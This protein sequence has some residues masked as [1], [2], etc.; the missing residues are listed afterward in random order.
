MIIRE[1]QTIYIEENGDGT[2]RYRHEHA[3]RWFPYYDGRPHTALANREWFPR[4]PRQQVIV[5][6][7]STNGQWGNPVFAD[8]DSWKTDNK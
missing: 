4:R 6:V 1:K 7:T 3:T 5:P 2:G 8:G